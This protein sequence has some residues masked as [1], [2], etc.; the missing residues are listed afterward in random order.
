[1][2]RPISLFVLL[3]V[4]SASGDEGM[5]TDQAPQMDVGSAGSYDGSYGSYDDT[6]VVDET[7]DDTTADDPL[8]TVTVPTSSPSISGSATVSGFDNAAA[9][10]VG[11]QT[12]FRKAV[13][14]TIGGGVSFEQV[15]VT[16]T[17]A[18]ARLRSRSRRL[19]DLAISYTVTFDTAQIK[20]LYFYHLAGASDAAATIAA[21]TPA[22]FLVTLTTEMTTAAVTVPESMAVASIAASVNVADPV[23]DPDAGSYNSSSVGSSVGSSMGSSE[24]GAS[25]RS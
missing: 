24:R 1:M 10:T 7:A 9:F 15:T 17:V 20:L 22:E 21:A 11:H 2:F 14:A 13:A 8:P 18:D 25:E 16:A 4:V 6:P 12:A 19:A 3:A 5:D 23:A